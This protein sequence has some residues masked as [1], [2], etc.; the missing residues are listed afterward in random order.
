VG[1]LSIVLLNVYVEVHCS[2]DC[3]KLNGNVSI[4]L[5]A[6]QGYAHDESSKKSIGV[7]MISVVWRIDVLLGQVLHSI[8]IG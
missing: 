5:Y 6:R 3:A 1:L 4:W 2:S 7:G 8:P